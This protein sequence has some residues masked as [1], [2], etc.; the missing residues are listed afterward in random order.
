MDF[1]FTEAQ[2]LLRNS[3]REFL[4]KECPKSY[5]RELEDKG[6][7]PE[8]VFRKMAEKGWL[9]VNIPEEYGGSGGDTVDFAIM[10]EEIA[11]CWVSLALDWG[12][13]TCFG[14]RTLCCHG[15]EEQRKSLLPKLCKGEKRFAGA[16]TEPGGGTDLLAMTTNATKVDDGWIVNGQK[17]F[18]T[19]ALE[20]DY[21]ITILRTE[22]NPAKRAGAFTIFLIDAKSKGVEIRKLHKLG[23]WSSDT[24]EIFFSD[25][26]VPDKS[27][28]GEVGRG[29]Y[30]LTDTLNNERIMVATLSIGNGQAAFEDALEY[31][32]QRYAFGRPIGQFQVIQKYLAELKVDI[33]A[34][35]L[36]VY[37][38][39]SMEAE[40]LPCGMEATMADY[41]ASEVAL[42]CATTGMRIMAGAGY[43]MENAMQ[44]YYRDAIVTVFAPISNEM[45]L[46]EVAR[47][48]LGLPRA[49]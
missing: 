25:V 49:Y 14:S 37:R 34:A 41:F 44:R 48:S 7:Y 2:L 38:A 30:L 43:M 15:S 23:V 16:F 42:K 9:G 47:H 17:T 12:T 46:D 1:K 18:I 21:L 24:N 39:A 36:L 8:Q 40:G 29:F 13:N 5:I 10:G 31:A 32:K 27:R 26:K 35:R 6:E 20:A 11:K 28:I 33:E 3:V 4:Q 22:K 45:C 19:A